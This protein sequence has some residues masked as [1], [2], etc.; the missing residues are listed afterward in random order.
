MQYRIRFVFVT[1]S[2]VRSGRLLPLGRLERWTTSTLNGSTSPSRKRS[3][4]TTHPTIGPTWAGTGK[5]CSRTRSTPSPPTSITSVRPRCPDL[6]PNRSSTCRSKCRTSKMNPPTYPPW[7]NWGWFSALAVRI[8]ASCDRPR[9]ARG[10]CT[11]TSAEWARSGPRNTS[12]SETLFERESWSG[13]RV[14]A[15]QT[16]I[17]DDRFRTRGLQPRQRVV[18]PRGCREAPISLTRHSTQ[19]DGRHRGQSSGYRNGTAT[20]CTSS[21]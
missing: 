18:H 7:K 12:P 17:G 1:G 9:D 10:M 13:T 5:T 15:H 19:G 11:S 4:S 20:I 21:S 2:R 3:R 14:R 6:P 16:R 8:S